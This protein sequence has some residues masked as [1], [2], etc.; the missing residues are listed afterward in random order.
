MTSLLAL[1]C[2]LQPQES[3]DNLFLIDSNDKVFV[4]G[5]KQHLIDGQIEQL[6]VSDN[7]NW[8]FV[9]RRKLTDR[10]YVTQLSENEPTAPLLLTL[11]DGLSKK[12]T[13]FSQFD[14]RQYTFETAAVFDSGCAVAT[15]YTNEPFEKIAVFLTPQGRIKVLFRAPAEKRP[16]VMTAPINGSGNVLI[17]TFTRDISP[18]G[19]TKEIA[20]L[21]MLG[22]DGTVVKEWPEAYQEIGVMTPY[23]DAGPGEV[24]FYD[25]DQAVIAFNPATGNKRLVHMEVHQQ[26]NK[27]RNKPIALESRPITASGS[28]Q[29]TALYVRLQNPKT[30]GAQDQ[31]LL[32]TRL[33]GVPAYKA[34]VAY[35]YDDAGLYRQPFPPSTLDAFTDWE[36]EQIKAKTMNRAKMIGTAMHIYGSDNEDHFPSAKTWQEDILAYTKMPEL[37]EGFSYL[38]NGDNITSI[39]N[40]TETII[41][42]ISTKYGDAVVYADSSV[43]WRDPPGKS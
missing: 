39:E 15:L 27:T 6:T 36:K 32:G 24:V 40:I 29:T 11:V 8:A 41:G 10:Q 26:Q 3:L 20:N 16:K 37:T 34:P 13:D 35:I 4:K 12:H 2:L 14:E 19:T 43:K 22:I 5:Q 17:Q 42:I 9:T 7:G 23:Y 31:V 25:K 1:V 38:L 30:E 28:E 18:D 21:Q 33:T